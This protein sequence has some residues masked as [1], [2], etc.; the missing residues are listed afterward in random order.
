MGK[1]TSF[2]QVVLGEVDDPH[3]LRK[4][5]MLLTTYIKVNWKWIKD[6][7]VKAKTIK[8]LEE[9]MAKFH[10]IGFDNALLDTTLKAQAAREKIDKLDFIKI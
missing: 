9:N 8:L 7:N 10:D 6:L 4:E 3:A 5:V 2:Q 1:E